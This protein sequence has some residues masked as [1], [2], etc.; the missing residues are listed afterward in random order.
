MCVQCWGSRSGSRS[1]PSSSP[2][3][4]RPQTGSN[5]STCLFLVPLEKLTARQ[6][7]SWSWGLWPILLGASPCQNARRL[8]F[9]CCL[10]WHVEDAEHATFPRIVCASDP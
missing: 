6:R 9:S 3:Q 4:I 8:F 2:L 7:L 1:P 10:L 5:L